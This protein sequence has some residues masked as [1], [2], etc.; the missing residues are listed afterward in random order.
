MSWLKLSN[1][2][3]FHHLVSQ[4]DCLGLP[5]YK[6]AYFYKPAW[7]FR[8]GL[9]MC[10]LADIWYHKSHVS[11]PKP[12]F[13]PTGTVPRWSGTKKFFD[14][15]NN[16]SERQ[17][18]FKFWQY[19]QLSVSVPTY[20][21]Q[22]GSTHDEKYWVFTKDFT[23]LDLWATIVRKIKQIHLPNYTPR[24]NMIRRLWLAMLGIFAQNLHGERNN[25]ALFPVN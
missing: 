3:I 20:K 18:C 17:K 25:L 1:F 6:P 16:T 14:P 12:R 4:K 22:V 2:W 9:D 11:Q 15:K 10:G 7:L 8:R 24:L 5:A 23:F 13:Q 21:Y 19:T